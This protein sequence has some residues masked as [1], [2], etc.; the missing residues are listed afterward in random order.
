MQ[1]VP[2]SLCSLLTLATLLP[3]TSR[4]KAQTFFT[5]QPAGSAFT[6]PYGEN[7]A[8]VIT[9]TYFTPFGNSYGFV[10][11][12]DGTITT[13]APPVNAVATTL[14]DVNNAGIATGAFVAK[15]ANHSATYNIAADAW[16]MLPD[17][18][19]TVGGIA[20]S[21]NNAN[22]VVGEAI[23]GYD[24]QGNPSGVHAYF[25]GNSGYTFFDAPGA[26]IAFAGTI[27][28]D[29]NDAGTVV[30]FYSPTG[31]NGLLSGFVRDSSGAYTTV[32]Y[33][34]ADSTFFEGIN[35]QGIVAGS[36][37]VGGVSHSFLWSA[38]NGFTNF[39]VP[40]GLNTELWGIDNYGHVVGNYIDP[41][42]GIIVG[43]AA[44]PEPG[45]V[46]LLL[47][48]SIPGMGFL[49]HR[50]RTAAKI[51]RQKHFQVVLASFLTRFMPRSPRILGV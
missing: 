3:L 25:Y 8:G 40:N 9:G 42:Q 15:F 49:A 23:G 5:I 20:V 38:G 11:S 33:P 28:E 12:P 47:G 2:K 32:D 1:T 13:P 6:I 4:V 39:D 29:I 36:Y 30:G 27:P 37:D 14:T 22:L 51:A 24:M 44:V 41:Q 19:G 17:I 48:M 34:G 10:R 43:F 50:R 45:N 18:M 35:N 46:A 26:D 21:I 16:T 7:D 31:R